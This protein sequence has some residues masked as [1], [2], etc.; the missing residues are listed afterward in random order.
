[1]KNVVATDHEKVWIFIEA[2]FH[3]SQLGAKKDK[4]LRLRK[5]LGNGNVGF[6]ETP[7]VLLCVSQYVPSVL[8]VSPEPVGLPHVCRLCHCLR[9]VS[10]LTSQV[11]VEPLSLILP[12][13]SKHKLSNR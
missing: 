2:C 10:S 13:E 12:P 3:L 9:V 4:R 11:A 5:G 8:E 1:M 6:D 7:F